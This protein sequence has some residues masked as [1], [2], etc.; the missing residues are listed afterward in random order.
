VSEATVGIASPPH[1]L[2]LLFSERD[3]HLLSICRLP[4][5]YDLCEPWCLLV[6]AGKIKAYAIMASSRL[7][8]APARP[9][10]R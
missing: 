1:L 10:P 5:R 6:R 9:R 3:R 4:Y 8:A 7:P 2:G